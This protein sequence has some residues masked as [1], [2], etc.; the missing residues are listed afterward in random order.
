MFQKPILIA[1]FNHKGG[2]SKTT[3]TFNL[4]WAFADKGIKTLI[5]DTDPQ[6]NLTASVLQLQDKQSIEAFY[7]DVDND[8]LYLKLNPIISGTTLS[9]ESV[10]PADTLNSNLKLVAGHLSMSDFDIQ[11]TAGLLSAEGGLLQFTTQF[12]GALNAVIRKTAEQ[13]QCQL[14]LIDMSPSSGAMN[15]SILMS[16]DYFLIPTSPD[17]FSYQAIQNLGDMFIN[18]NNSFKRFRKSS[19]PNALPSVPPKMLGVISQ[20]YRPYTPRKKEIMEHVPIIGDKKYEE[21][22]KGIA[23]A[24]KEWIDKIQEASNDLLAKKLTPYNMVINKESFVRHITDE[25]P[26]NLISIGDFN[27]LIASSQK[28]GK[29]IF[30]LTEEEI[31]HTGKSLQ[32][33]KENQELFKELFST[34]AD[35]VC[36]LIEDD[37]SGNHK[38]RLVKNK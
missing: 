19:L 26:Y 4:G 3:T 13:N 22:K 24:Y 7:R 33:M 15:R 38:L 8:N 12:V 35:R 31:Q 6:C 18:W 30:K 11:V 25:K 17:F 16:S 36:Y 10:K 21:R 2:V 34:L 23:K 1:L 20:K 9:I 27:S 32:E 28:Y 29:P 5:V 37:Y 14:V